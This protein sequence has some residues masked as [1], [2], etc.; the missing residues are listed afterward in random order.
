MTFSEGQTSLNQHVINQSSKIQVD[1]PSPFLKM[2]PTPLYTKLLPTPLYTKLQPTPHYTKLLP[3]PLYAK[4]LP[5][6]LHKKL[7]PTPHYTRLLPHPL[8]TK[9]LP[10]T[11]VI[12]DPYNNL[13]VI[14]YI[15]VYKTIGY[16]VWYK[17]Y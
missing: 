11:K 15:Y 5:T 6:P 3:T 4:C 10:T 14:I 8:Y 16:L 12:I 2:L 1:T 9:L 13:F 17:I 7:L